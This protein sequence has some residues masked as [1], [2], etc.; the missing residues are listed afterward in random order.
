MCFREEKEEIPVK[1]ESPAIPPTARVTPVASLALPEVDEDG[2]SKQPAKP[3]WENQKPEDKRN[4]K[5]S[6]I[7]GRLVIHGLFHFSW[8]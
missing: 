7:N 3:M 8:F 2:Y 5:S 6:I 1:S 4:Y